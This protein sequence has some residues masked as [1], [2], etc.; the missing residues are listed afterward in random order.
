MF[1]HKIIFGILKYLRHDMGLISLTNKN[2]KK[3]PFQTS[4][5]IFVVK[6]K[7][8]IISSEVH[9]KNEMVSNLNLTRWKSI[10]S[11]NELSERQH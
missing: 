11:Q 10:V 9:L 7:N 3:R 5:K 1:V 2:F 6:Q 8:Q 4:L